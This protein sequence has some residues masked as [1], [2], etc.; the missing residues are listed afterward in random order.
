M[1]N[2]NTKWI[3]IRKQEEQNEY[4]SFVE[5][6]WSESGRIVLRIASEINYIA[7]INGQRAAFGQF[8][9]YKNEKYYDEI[10]ITDFS[11]PGENELRI[12]VR[13]E[14]IDTSNHIKDSAGVIFE[15]TQAGK[16]LCHSCAETLGGLDTTYQQHV[17]R[18]VTSQ[19]GYAVDMCYGGSIQYDVCREVD[20]PYRFVK[21]PVKKLVEEPLVFG[22]KIE[23][24]DK[25]IYDF[26]KETVMLRQS[27][28]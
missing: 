13:Y 22:E 10:D 6:Y 14:G 3:W 19:I 5:K 25:N 27:C 17:C 7:Y 12:V 21:R 16:V 18:L 1:F 2:T 4:A 11:A 28:F 26:G 24:P 8:P 23:L 15:I 20:L 9:N